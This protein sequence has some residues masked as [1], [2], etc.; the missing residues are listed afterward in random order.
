M[1]RQHRYYCVVELSKIDK[2]L[3]LLYNVINMEIMFSSFRNT[4]ICFILFRSFC[5]LAP[6]FFLKYRAFQSFDVERTRWRIFLKIK[7]QRFYSY[8]YNV[9]LQI[10]NKL[11]LSGVVYLSHKLIKSQ[12][13]WSFMFVVSYKWVWKQYLKT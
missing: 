11:Q 13:K 1:A 12:N 7:Y 3:Q 6:I 4:L 8:A 10:Q 2:N 5:F 9:W